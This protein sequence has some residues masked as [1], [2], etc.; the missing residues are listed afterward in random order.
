VAFSLAD[1]GEAWRTPDF[2]NYGSSPAF[3]MCGATPT[4][5]VMGLGG[6]RK[7]FA[8][9]DVMGFDAKDGT[10]V[11]S[12]SAGKTYYNS[13]P[14]I[15]NDGLVM[16]EGGGG[17]GPT[18]ALAPPDPQTGSTKAAVLWKDNVHQV[19][20]S[21][22]MIYR[23]LVFGQGHKSDGRSPHLLWCADAADGTITWDRPPANP[24]EGHQMMLASDGR[25]LQLHEN[26]ELSMFD[27]DA[28]D[29]YKELGRAK[30]LDTKTN[31]II[32]AFPALVRGRLYARGNA[33]LICVDLAK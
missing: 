17:A 31:G 27:A 15:A 26:G 30:L 8:G 4:V 33:E 1:G 20:F 13:P 2:G 28:R 24:K 9:G 32:Y 11:W 5:V 14:P 23:G 18:Y 6:N 16:I 22:Y 25:I 7:S 19:R 21:N 3:M 29:G 10:L 12:A